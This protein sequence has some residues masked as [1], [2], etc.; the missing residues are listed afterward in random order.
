MHG[1]F[2]SPDPL[3]AS[4][5]TGNPQTWNRYTYVGNNPLFWV[6]PTGL[7]WGKNDNGDV[8]WF[9]KKLGKGFSEFT[10]ENWQYL[11]DKGRVIQ[12]DANSSN[13]NYIDPVKVEAEFDPIQELVQSTGQ[14]LG[15]SITGLQIGAR[16]AVTG[17]LNALTNP[18]GPAGAAAGVPNLLEIDPLEPG[19]ASQAAY[20]LV[21]ETGVTAMA[22]AGV[23]AAAAGPASAGSSLSVVPKTEPGLYLAGKAP[24]QIGPGPRVLEGQRI[25]NLGRV[26]PWRAHYDAFGRQIARTDFNAGNKT[27][28]IPAIHHVLYGYNNG[29]RFTIRNH[30]PGIF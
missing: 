14:N 20:A 29:I 28:G 13:W 11:G 3:M 23:G 4:G 17:G 27:A 25:N 22:S 21:A 7:I 10:P 8:R 24:W 26:E 16:N 18:L 9:D 15:D 5:G 19:N 2:T 1:R 12:L 6:D 30:I